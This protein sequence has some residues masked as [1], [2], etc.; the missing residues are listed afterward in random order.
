M[1]RWRIARVS[2]SD[3]QRPDGRVIM[4]ET[5]RLRAAT[6]ALR[7]HLDR[8]PIDFQWDVTGDRF[9]AG[10]AFM[11]ARHRYGCAESM[12]G[13][14][15]GGTVIGAIARSLLIDGLRWQWIGEQPDRR[16]TLLGELRDERN[17]L[18]IRLE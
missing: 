11:G 2:E 16:R 10:I 12:L 1:E 6:R 8:L 13:A 9:L 7:L 3:Q 17:G 5:R 18:L 4:P 14:G 15:F